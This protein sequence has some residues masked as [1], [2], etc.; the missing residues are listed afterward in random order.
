MLNPP[1]VQLGLW[2]ELYIHVRLLVVRKIS[3]V[4]FTALY[5]LGTDW[6]NGFSIVNMKKAFFSFLFP[7][8]IATAY[9][10]FPMHAK[11]QNKINR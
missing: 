3:C 9:C 4:N 5:L 8:N 2:T 10:L 6:K 7:R 1:E 11:Q